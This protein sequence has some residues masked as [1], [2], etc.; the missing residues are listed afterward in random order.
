MSWID[1][2]ENQLAAHANAAKAIE[3]IANIVRGALTA[4]GH[5]GA[6]DALGNV[7]T[8]SEA[9]INGLT[10]AANPVDVTQT[11]DKFR[12]DIDAADKAA[13]AEA[14]RRFDHSEK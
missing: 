13:D 9:V 6:A 11:I 8:I 10:G 12:A 5:S 3:T 1:T 4:D 14:D 2:V 7:L